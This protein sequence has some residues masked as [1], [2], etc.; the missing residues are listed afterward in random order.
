MWL[1]CMRYIRLGAVVAISQ[2]RPHQDSYV[3]VA[4]LSLERFVGVENISFP[5]D[6]H[7][8][9]RCGAVAAISQIRPHQDS[10]VAVATLSLERFVGVENISFPTIG[11]ECNWPLAASNHYIACV[12]YV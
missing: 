10:Y 11:T 3:A 12:T 1:Y 2:I 9:V 4:T 5:T 8:D 6:R 7:R